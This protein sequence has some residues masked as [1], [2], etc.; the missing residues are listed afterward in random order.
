MPRD[1]SGPATRGDGEADDDARDAGADEAEA[2]GGA[3]RAAAAATARATRDREQREAKAEIESAW[4]GI[5]SATSGGE[6]TRAYH[7]L[8]RVVEREERRFEETCGAEA[9]A[10]RGSRSALALIDSLP[11]RSEWKTLVV[12]VCVGDR[13]YSCELGEQA[14]ALRVLRA[15]GLWCRNRNSPTQYSILPYDD[16]RRETYCTVLGE[17]ALDGRCYERSRESREGVDRLLG[18]TPEVD[19]RRIKTYATAA[20]ATMLFTDDLAS[21]NVRNGVMQSLLAPLVRVVCDEG[22]DGPGWEVSSEDTVAKARD[23]GEDCPS[24]LEAGDCENL[25]RMLTQARLLCVAAIGDY[26]ECFAE[27]LQHGALR[28]SLRLLAGQATDSGETGW[29]EAFGVKRQFDHPASLPGDPQLPEALSLCSA[30]LAHRKFAISFIDGGGAKMLTAVPRGPLTYHG[31]TRCMFG[32]AS[33]TTALERL[34][35]PQVNLA[36]K[37]VKVA[38]EMLDCANEYARRH[39]ALF[40]TFA[41]Q[42]PIVV[43]AYDA[44]AGLKHVLTLLR[45][46][47]LFVSDETRMRD[48]GLSA[49]DIAMAKE[50]GNHMSLLLRQYMRAHFIQHVKSIEE[51]VLGKAKKKNDGESNGARASK[52]EQRRELFQAIDITQDA[53]DRYFSMVNRQKRIAA[54]MQTKSWLVIEA[55]IAQ[56]GPKVMLDL[57]CFA[58][59]DQVLRECVSSSLTVL[60]IVTAHP[61]GRVATASSKLDTNYTSGYLLVDIIGSAADAVDTDVVVESLKVLCNMLVSPHALQNAETKDVQRSN[62]LQRSQSMDGKSLAVFDYDRMEE[63]FMT[64]RK[65]IQEARGVRMLLNLLFK[66]SKTLPQPSM[67]I[68]RALSCRALLGLSRD[69]SI[70]HTLQTLQIARHLSELIRETGKSYKSILDSGDAP[71]EANREHGTGSAATVQAAAAEFHQCAVELIAAT[72]GFANVKATTPAVASD[73][74]APPL[75]KLERHLIAAATK[76]RYPHEE[77]LQVIHEHLVAAGLSKTASSLLTE[78][79]LERLGPARSGSVTRLCSS[80]PPRLKLNFKSKLTHNKVRR[81]APRS[82]MTGAARGLLGKV[83]EPFTLGLDSGM[84]HVALKE[85]S[86]EARKVTD[87]SP[88]KLSRGQKRKSVGEDLR[89]S[90]VTPPIHAKDLATCSHGLHTPSPSVKERVHKEFPTPGV[91]VADGPRGETGCGVRSRLDSILTQYL[92]AQ[93]RQ[94]TAPITACAPFSLL[95]PHQCPTAK[96]VLDAPRN[97]SSRLHRREWANVRGWGNGMRRADRHFLY[98]RFRPIRTLREAEAMITASTFVYGFPDHLIAGTDDGEFYLYDTITSALL[99]VRHGG[100]V[101]AVRKMVP[102]GPRCQKSMFVA[103]CGHPRSV[104]D[105][106]H[107][108]VWSM[109][110]E[111][112][113]EELYFEQAYGGA[114]NSTGTTIAFS[115]DDYQ[116]RLVDMETRQVTRTLSAFLNDRVSDLWARGNDEVSFAPND[117][118]LLWDETLWDVRTSSASPVQRFDRFSEIAGACFHPAGNEIIIGREVWDIRSSRLLRTVPSLNRAALKFN[119]SG[120]VGLAHIL[121]PRHETIHSALKKCHHPYK[122]SFCTI[123]MADYSDICTVDV[124][125][126]I[127]DAAW[128]VD[129]DMTCATVEYDSMLDAPES[130]IRLHEVGRLPATGDES[131]VEDDP[132][133]ENDFFD[134]HFTEDEMNEYFDEDEDFQ[135]END[136]VDADGRRTIDDRRVQR[137]AIDG[138]RTLLN[139]EDPRGQPWIQLDEL[140][141][142]YDSDFIDSDY[143]GDDDEDPYERFVRQSGAQDVRIR[144]GT[145]ADGDG[146]EIDLARSPRRYEEYEAGEEDVSDE[147]DHDS[148][149]DDSDEDDHDSDD[150]HSGSEFTDDDDS[151]DSEDDEDEDEDDSSTPSGDWADPSDADVRSFGDR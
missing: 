106:R 109:D 9:S 63:T 80:P 144:V 48:S 14:G 121:H 95:T 103:T 125:R 62:R 68:T 96:H 79:H 108:S 104:I 81:R 13:M 34:I 41:V 56:D 117:N 51:K 122:H 20:L 130:V 30:F 97:L 40:L 53:T 110:A 118:L 45:T 78:A 148:E 143:S 64:A 16:A 91:L 145:S 37:Y 7:A 22:G 72:A 47:A 82:R 23:A 8:A 36:R 26:V 57:L 24:G 115:R 99:D 98:S 137:T 89:K 69:E 114:L 73:A 5:K 61:S 107:V 50:T 134:P 49:Y 129:D 10:F 86:G 52:N 39:A 113:I 12:D 65:H 27:A 42:I 43:V 55:F 59:G 32:I 90:L 151:Y 4:S 66:T 54:V 135:Y 116:V 70:A 85:L 35:S 101:G 112:G 28:L 132:P 58:P 33:I 18:R 87:P 1:G 142:E 149:D 124:E 25:H 74:A 126:S 31:V 102:T 15:C 19:M 140:S 133:G 120:N 83:D 17:L 128:C 75:A 123:D 46:L 119:S 94:C 127:V 2:R 111:N 138:L 88:G 139:G 3:V 6:R 141:S 11:V 67:N 147:D 44:E 146:F 29:P 21:D 131:D 76:V 71:R 38:I 93:H 100:R 77:L 84:T 105:N 92:R 60:K 136:E 150:D